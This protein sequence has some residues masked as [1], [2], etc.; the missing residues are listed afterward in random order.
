MALRLLVVIGIAAV[1]ACTGANRPVHASPQVFKIS[2]PPTVT[3]PAAA[4]FAAM[5]TGPVMGQADLQAALTTLLGEHADL[6]AAVMRSAADDQPD[7]GAVAALQANTRRLT[8]AIG[9]VYGADGAGAFQQLWG[10]HSQ[11]FADYA[12]AAGDGDGTARQQALDRLDDYHRDFASFADTA[13]AGAA[14][15]AAV[16]GLLRAHVADLTAYVEAYASGDGREASRRLGAARSYMG[17]IAG[18]L[19]GAISKQDPVRFPPTV[20]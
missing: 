2:E 1:T 17:V 4:A 3:L 5:A 8:D 12:T 19:A 15:A 14:P 11:F 10:Q 9:T 16:Q 13:T 18:A 6:V 20:G 7:R